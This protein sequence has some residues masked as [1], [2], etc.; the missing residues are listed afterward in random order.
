M[1]ARMDGVV[2]WRAIADD[3]EQR[4]NDGGLEAGERLPTEN[5]FADKFNVNRHTVRRALSDLQARG[6]I[7]VTQGRGSF[8]RRPVISYVVTRQARFE[9]LFDRDGGDADR[10]TI[11]ARVCSADR[12][13]A[14]VFGVERQ[15]P[16][17]L[18]EERVSVDDQPV[19]LADHYVRLDTLPRF[20][21]AYPAT[22]SI[23]EALSACGVTG[24]ARSVTQM[25]ARAASPRELSALDLP[26]HAPLLL[27]DSVIADGDAAPVSLTRVRFA[28]DRIDVTFDSVRSC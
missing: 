20:E 15:C 26:R 28:S 5:E 23:R 17:F 25:R 1:L 10:D 27:V 8:V 16:L 13:V 22:G 18:L 11:S 21:S 4:I 6:L 3:I 7:E 19:A 9:D 2:L 14:R 24:L 12:D